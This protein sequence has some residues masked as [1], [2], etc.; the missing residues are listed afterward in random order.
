MHINC[1]LVGDCQYFS[2]LELGWLPTFADLEVTPPGVRL[3]RKLLLLSIFGVSLAASL[4]AVFIVRCL[5]QE[6]DKVQKDR[7]GLYSRADAIFIFFHASLVYSALGTGIWAGVTGR[8]SSRYGLILELYVLAA[9]E[10]LMTSLLHATL[11]SDRV[12]PEHLVEAIFPLGERF[13]LVRDATAL[14]EYVRAGTTCS[15]LGAVVVILSN[16][17]ASV[18]IYSRRDDLRQLRFSFWP[19]QKAHEEGTTDLPETLKPQDSEVQKPTQKAGYVH[20]EVIDTE[21]DDSGSE[22]HHDTKRS[23]MQAAL[24]MGRK[25]MLEKLGKGTS[26]AQQMSSIW[27]QLPQAIIGTLVLVTLDERSPAILLCV[28]FAVAQLVFIEFCRPAILCWQA[29]YDVEWQNV[30]PRDFRRTTRSCHWPPQAGQ[31]AL[32]RIVLKEGIDVEDREAAAEELGTELSKAKEDDPDRCQN[33]T[34]EIFKRLIKEDE[35]NVL[36]AFAAKAGV[37]VEDANLTSGPAGLQKWPMVALILNYTK[38]A[39][40]NYC[41]L[42][43]EDFSNFLLPALDSDLQLAYINLNDNKK[44]VHSEVGLE[45]LKNFLRLT[46]QLETLRLQRSCSEALMEQ[47]RNIWKD[48]GRNPTGLQLE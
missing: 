15:S 14:A 35:P 47:V 13:D 46:P 28:L 37:C 17:A 34:T 36:K 11:T 31:R 27:E 25:K 43:E 7:E 29:A 5:R 21:D 18:A 26:H 45:N 40:V 30:C 4:V 24:Q 19:A 9:L 39:H 3:Q 41:K 12:G 10:A 23:M 38:R 22:S 48:F 6:P 20:L 2:A 42:T 16:L 33:I 8:V 32:C 44:L 1:E